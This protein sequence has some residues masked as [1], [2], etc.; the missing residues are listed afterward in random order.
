MKLKAID[1]ND[2]TAHLADAQSTVG[3]F[4]RDNY[5]KIIGASVGASVGAYSVYYFGLVMTS[6]YGFCS[7]YLT[8][9]FSYFILK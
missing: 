1:L 5:L 8:K 3:R 6:F 9:P 4:L 2:L 7:N